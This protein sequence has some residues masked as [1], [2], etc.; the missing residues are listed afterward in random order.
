MAVAVAVA[1]EEGRGGEVHRR[2]HVVA[3][4][5]LLIRAHGRSQRSRWRRRSTGRAPC[6]GG[7]LAAVVVVVAVAGIPQLPGVP[8]PGRCRSRIC[9]TRYL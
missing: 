3:S 5:E 7:C 9:S 8:V 2:E 4:S 1:E 6:S